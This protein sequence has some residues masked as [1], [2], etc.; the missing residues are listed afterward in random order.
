MEMGFY[1]NTPRVPGTVITK[2]PN[3]ILN[4]EQGYLHSCY[5]EHRQ[6]TGHRSTV[7]AA[8]RIADSFGWLDTHL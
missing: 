7:L 4:T 6:L 3:E 2:A 8:A 5:L 1:S